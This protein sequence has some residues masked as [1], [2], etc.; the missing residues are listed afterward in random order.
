MS[1]KL[2]TQETTKVIIFNVLILNLSRNLYIITRQKLKN[3][4][5][6]KKTEARTSIS[7]LKRS[8]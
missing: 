5:S 8:C 4:N 3:Y 7:N 6:Q 1:R 2:F